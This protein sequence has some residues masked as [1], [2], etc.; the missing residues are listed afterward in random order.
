M[1]FKIVEQ[2][3][4]CGSMLPWTFSSL[5]LVDVE[6][7]EPCLVCSTDSSSLRPHIRYVVDDFEFFVPRPLKK[8]SFFFP[9]HSRFDKLT[10]EDLKNDNCHFDE[11]PF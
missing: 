9:E 7:S 10:V 3:L 11:L 1:E 6:Y 2:C 4:I 5:P 8:V